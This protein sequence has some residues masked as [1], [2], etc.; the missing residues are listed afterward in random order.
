MQLLFEAIWSTG[1]PPCG[2]P[3]VERGWI[4][5]LRTAASTSCSAGASSCAQRVGRADGEEKLEPYWYEP[6]HPDGYILRAVL[7]AP[8]GRRKLRW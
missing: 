5:I 6:V 2:S 8:E 7:L 1:G 3:P 4:V